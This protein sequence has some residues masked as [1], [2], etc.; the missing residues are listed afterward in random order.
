MMQEIQEIGAKSFGHGSRV[1]GQGFVVL[2]ALARKPLTNGE[3]HAS[4]GMKPSEF[5]QLLDRLRRNRLVGVVSELDGSGVKQTLCLTD[6]GE[7]VLLREME[8]MCELPER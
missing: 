3:L 4:F 5:G 2:L 6:E 7:R 8:Q 1:S